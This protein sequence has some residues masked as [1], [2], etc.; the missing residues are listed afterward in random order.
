MDSSVGTFRLSGANAPQ[1]TACCTARTTTIAGLAS[2]TYFLKRHVCGK[3]LDM[4]F[5]SGRRFP[6]VYIGFGM[7]RWWKMWIFIIF[8]ARFDQ[9][10]ELGLVMALVGC[11]WTLVP[12]L[13]N[14]SSDIPRWNGWWRW[15]PILWPFCPL[16]WAGE[17]FACFFF[18]CF[19]VIDTNFGWQ[20]EHS[21]FGKLKMQ[22][23]WMLKESVSIVDVE[24]NSPES[25]ALRPRFVFEP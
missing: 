5:V 1:N 12:N 7:Q 10:H 16:T 8:S 25:G 4:R 21:W 23:F 14:C 19:D 9:R 13:R 11:C 3:A 24:F 20:A 18:S 6:I 2:K 22:C 15:Y 17:C